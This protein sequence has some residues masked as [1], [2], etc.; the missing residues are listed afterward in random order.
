VVHADETGWSIKS[1]WA[2]LSE[3]VSVCLFGVP[4]SGATLAAVLDQAA[5]G[6]VLVSDDAAV[7]QNFSKAQ[8]GWGPPAPQ[9]N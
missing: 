7:Y 1:V 5:F 3:E 4:K 8:K 9:G 6:G 2:F